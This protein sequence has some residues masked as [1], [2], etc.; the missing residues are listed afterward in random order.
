LIVHFY[1]SDHVQKIK[2]TIKCCFK[3]YGTISDTTPTYAEHLCIVL[4]MVTLQWDIIEL[5]IRCRAFLTSFN[6]ETLAGSFLEVLEEDYDVNLV[7]WRVNMGDRCAV[8]GAM[9]NKIIE[10][11]KLNVTSVGCVS[12][13][14]CNS[15]GHFDV[16]HA[17]RTSKGLTKMVKYPLCKARQIFEEAFAEKA[18]KSGGTR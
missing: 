1:R 9:L 3:E 11:C 6:S 16:P 14:I 15:G 8:N 4:R 7:D 10:H 18:L 13:G 2:A 5:T 12:H 17:D